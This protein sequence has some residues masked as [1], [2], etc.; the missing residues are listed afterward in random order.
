MVDQRKTDAASLAYR[1]L[2]RSQTMPSMDESRR[3]ALL[4][5]YSEVASNFR[6]LTDIRFKLLAFLPIAAAAAAAFRSDRAT[7]QGL[8]LSLFGLVVTLG[9]VTYNSRNDQLY[10]ELVDRA[11]SI[12]RSLGLPDGGFANRPRPWLVVN[13]LGKD[14]Q[15]DHGTGVGTIYVASIAFWLFGV[16]ASALELVRRPYAA[17]GA[18]LSGGVEAVVRGFGPIASVLELVQHSTWVNLIAGGLAV[19]LT[20]WG[21]KTIKDQEKKIRKS[22]RNSAKKAVKEAISKGAIPFKL[23]ELLDDNDFLVPCEDLYGDKRD[24]IQDRLRFYAE[25][26]QVSLGY[27]LPRGSHETLSAS[28]LVALLTDLPP[29][30][31]FNCATNR[32]GTLT[33]SDASGDREGVERAPWWRRMFGR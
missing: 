3:D 27:Y 18:E 25:L 13:L 21:A 8:A 4:K 33:T 5:E 31:I 15:F 2:H 30:W 14:W 20:W 32:L 23:S 16:F 12:E 17:S 11:A 9:L 28:H 26:D 7:V 10:N 6:L 19:L 22:M 1:G 29:Q 24:K